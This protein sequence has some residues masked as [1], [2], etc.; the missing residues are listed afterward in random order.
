MVLAMRLD[1]ALIKKLREE[2]CWSQEQLATVAGLSTRTVQRAENAG[3]ASLESRAA[4]A[5]AFGLSSAELTRKDVDQNVTDAVALPR[6][7]MD[8]RPGERLVRQGFANL[9]RGW[10]TVGGLICLTSERLRFDSHAINVQPGRTEIRLAE[11]ETVRP[12]WTKFLN[13]IPIFPNSLAIHVAG[14]K[15]YR[16]VLWGRH[17]WKKIILAQSAAAKA[18][19]AG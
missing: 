11:I 7:A 13:V 5:A 6:M 15:E 3:S 14:G 10:E 18:R 9:Q 19:A 16:F 12:C 8:R 17:H 1:G 4:I 2:R